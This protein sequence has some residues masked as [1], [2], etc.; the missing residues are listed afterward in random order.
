MQFEQREIHTPAGI[1][2]VLVVSADADT[3]FGAEKLAELRTS[4]DLTTFNEIAA[5]IDQGSVPHAVCIRGRGPDGSGQFRMAPSLDDEELDE[6][7]YRLLRALMPAMRRITRAGVMLVAAVELRVREQAALRAGA[8][9]LLA[10]VRQSVATDPTERRAAAETQRV[11]EQHLIWSGVGL[12]TALT[13]LLPSRLDRE[14]EP[15]PSKPDPDLRP[16]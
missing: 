1:R 13:E 4:V 12:E 2:R 5:Q 6:L 7:G 15:N 14:Q 10:R 3:V 11:L 16:A 9:R 8:A